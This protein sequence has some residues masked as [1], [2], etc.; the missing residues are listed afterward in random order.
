MTCLHT[1]FHLPQITRKNRT[2]Q[3]NVCETTK[4]TES[5]CLL[6]DLKL[7]WQKR[8]IC[9]FVKYCQISCTL[10]RTRQQIHTH[11]RTPSKLVEPCIWNLGANQRNQPNDY[12][13][14]SKQA[15]S[16]HTYTHSLFER[17]NEAI[18]RTV[19]ASIRSNRNSFSSRR[20]RHHHRQQ[21]CSF[22]INVI[23]VTRND[24]SFKALTSK[25]LDPGLWLLPLVLTHLNNIFLSQWNKSTKF[26]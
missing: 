8:L 6:N 20:R 3:K 19:R 16:K 13:I 7:F 25:C 15:S 26:W 17:T 10:N 4:P 1:I 18:R 23:V 5:K 22:R 11:A 24:F 14:H 9:L 2:D 12:Y 21:L